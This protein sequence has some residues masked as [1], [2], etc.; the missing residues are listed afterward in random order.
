MWNCSFSDRSLHPSKETLSASWKRRQ[1]YL[2]DRG[3]SGFRRLER[4]GKKMENQME[5]LEFEDY[6]RSHVNWRIWNC[7]KDIRIKTELIRDLRKNRNLSRGYCWSPDLKKVLAEVFTLTA[8][9]TL[10][11][12]YLF[13]FNWLNNHYGIFNTEI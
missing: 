7:I 6:G 13:D 2:P 8:F 4:K 9:N 11:I 12:V 10:K 5:T 1:K 3:C